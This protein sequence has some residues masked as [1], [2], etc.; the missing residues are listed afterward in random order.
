MNN[1]SQVQISISNPPSQAAPPT[2]PLCWRTF[3]L[4]FVK[5]GS[6]R[7]QWGFFLLEQEALLSFGAQDSESDQYDQNQ[8]PS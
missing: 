7:E 3:P 8:G 2:A 1:C 5:E 4:L 6:E